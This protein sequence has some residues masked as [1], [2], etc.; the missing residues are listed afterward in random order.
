MFTSI[1]NA[2]NSAFNAVHSFCAIRNFSW[3]RP[4]SPETLK[5]AK[6]GTKRKNKIKTLKSLVSRFF[7]DPEKRLL[8]HRGIGVAHNNWHKSNPQFKRLSGWH[9]LDRKHTK[10]YLRFMNLK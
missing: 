6:L 4:K 8:K 3:K 2:F 10:K 7:Y 5:R 1:K 9:Y